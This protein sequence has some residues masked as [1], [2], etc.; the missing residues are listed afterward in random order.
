V[1]AKAVPRRLALCSSNAKPD[2][3]ATVGMNVRE[4]VAGTS[5]L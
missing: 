3:P 5:Q 1:P 2:A 4:T